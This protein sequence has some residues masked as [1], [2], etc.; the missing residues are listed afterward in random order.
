M[1]L[2]KRRRTPNSWGIEATA[3]PES[4]TEGSPLRAGS[5][6]AWLGDGLRCCKLSI[7]KRGGGRG[8]VSLGIQNAEFAVKFPAEASH[9]V[10]RPKRPWTGPLLEGGHCP[11]RLSSAAI[12][13]NWPRDPL[14]F[15]RPAVVRGETGRSPAG[16]D[17]AGRPRRPSSYEEGRGPRAKIAWDQ[18]HR[19]DVKPEEELPSR[20][21]GLGEFPFRLDACC[22]RTAAIEE[23]NAY[24]LLTRLS[25]RGAGDTTR[26]PVLGEFLSRYYPG[27]EVSTNEKAHPPTCLL[28]VQE[29][30]RRAAIGSWR[31]SG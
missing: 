19:P 2:P 3:K 15:P 27:L 11:A 6:G 4:G 21:E 5:R 8:I 18:F 9:S 30:F 12:S 7:T 23:R 24:L 1:R 25:P 26:R 13:S 20:A 17:T 31:R 28:S 22:C 29:P 16:W 14:A 10:W